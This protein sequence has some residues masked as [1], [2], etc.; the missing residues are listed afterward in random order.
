MRCFSVESPSAGKDHEPRT[1]WAGSLI[2][3]CLGLGFAASAVE[4]ERVA[5]TAQRNRADTL[6]AM[7][8]VHEG[9]LEDVGKF[10]S[11]P[12]T[13]LIRL[14]P[15][16]DAAVSSAVIAWN[17]AEQRGY[18]F[19]DELPVLDTG[20]RY[21]LWAVGAANPVKLAS[22]EARVGSSVYAFQ[23]ETA[24][25]GKTRVEVTAGARSGNKVAIL[26]GEID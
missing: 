4:Y 18:L 2:L 3:A 12:Q 23:A 6:A 15:S 24:I 1:P 8:S 16:D 20:E 10:L 11:N 25:A 22:I 7:D 14:A 17:S 13:R 26:A 9:R 5:A 21:E 19:C